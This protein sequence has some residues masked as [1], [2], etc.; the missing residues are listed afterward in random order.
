MPPQALAY[1]QAPHYSMASIELTDEQWPL[2]VPLWQLFPTLRMISLKEI[3][4]LFDRTLAMI[5]QVISGFTLLIIVLSGVVVLASIQAVESKERQKNSIIMSFGFS[6][7]TC[8]KLNVIEWF[9]TALIS[10]VGAIVG[11]YLAGQLIYQSQFSLTY[12]PNVTWLLLTLFSIL[13]VMTA[14]GVYGSRKSLNS[15]VRALLVSH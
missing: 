7:S 9:V 4:E 2:L 11:T 3:T 10:A 8:L 12:Q 5:T 14:L 15:S 1:I 13:T 6:R